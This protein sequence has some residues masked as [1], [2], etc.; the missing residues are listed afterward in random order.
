MFNQAKKKKYQLPINELYFHTKRNK[1]KEL[2]TRGCQ[3][4]TNVQKLD[5]KF[6]FH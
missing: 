1:T 2:I 4:S 5:W 6:V 3:I